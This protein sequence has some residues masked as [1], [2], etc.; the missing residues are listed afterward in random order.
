MRLSELFSHANSGVRKLRPTTFDRASCLP[1]TG[2]RA[3][4]NGQSCC[5]MEVYFGSL[6]RQASRAV[7]RSFESHFLCRLLGRDNS[8]LGKSYLM[9]ESN[10]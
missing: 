6:I 10:Y 9:G 3:S 7:Y 4:K 8:S 5:Q 1:R 2:K